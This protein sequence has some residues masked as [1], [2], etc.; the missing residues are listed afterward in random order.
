MPID[1]TSTMEDNIPSLLLAIMENTTFVP[2]RTY[3]HLGPLQWIRAYKNGEF[4]LVENIGTVH[5]DIYQTKY[6]HQPKQCGYYF[7]KLREIYFVQLQ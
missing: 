1:K 4:L 2:I 6:G 5:L 3:L 7:P